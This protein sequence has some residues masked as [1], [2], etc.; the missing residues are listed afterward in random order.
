MTLLLNW[1]LWAAIGLAAVLAFAGVNIYRKGEHSVQ[2]KWDAA[3]VAT[4]R[5]AQEQAARNRDLQRQAEI[6][7]VVKREAQDRYIVTTVKEIH[8]AAAPLATCPVPPDV[9]RLLNGANHCA[10]GDSPAACGAD[11]QVPGP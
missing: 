3:N 2:V 11:G 7:Y 4:E 9:V 8:E 5:A 6:N 1:R 10:S